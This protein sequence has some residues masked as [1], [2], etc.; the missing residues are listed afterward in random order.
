[1]KRGRIILGATLTVALVAMLSGLYEHLL[2]R[3]LFTK[4]KRVLRVL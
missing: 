1:M 4:R 3:I 2:M